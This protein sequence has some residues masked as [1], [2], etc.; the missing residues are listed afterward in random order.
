MQ[1]ACLQICVLSLKV[2]KGKI[3]GHSWIPWS[4]EWSLLLLTI[5]FTELSAYSDLKYEKSMRPRL[6][7][8]K[9]E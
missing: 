8:F 7:N 2:N 4:F 3:E 6:V 9:N 5:T 1:D